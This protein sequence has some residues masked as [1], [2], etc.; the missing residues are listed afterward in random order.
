MGIKKICNITLILKMGQFI[1]V[2]SSY[3]KLEPKYSC[4]KKIAVPKK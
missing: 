2:T 3:T 1:C 4:K